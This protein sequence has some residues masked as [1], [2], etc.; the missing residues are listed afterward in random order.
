[1]DCHNNN[2]CCRVILVILSRGAKTYRRDRRRRELTKIEIKEEV[3]SWTMDLSE[4]EIEV[5]VFFHEKGKSKADYLR[6]EK[7]DIVIPKKY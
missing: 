3:N 6:K 4:N 5:I 7:G 1:M 2:R